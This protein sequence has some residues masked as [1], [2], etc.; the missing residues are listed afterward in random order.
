MERLAPIFKELSAA[1]PATDAATRADLETPA[2]LD[3][4]P[5]PL[6]VKRR[7]MGPAMHSAETL[8]AAARVKEAVA[9]LREAELELENDPWIGPAPPTVMAEVASTYEAE[10]F[11]E[12]NW[13][14]Y[15]NS[16]AQP[17]HRDGGVSPPSAPNNG[18]LG[19]LQ[20]GAERAKA[21]VESSLGTEPRIGRSV[22]ETVAQWR[23]PLVRPII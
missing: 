6:E 9:R 2:F 4:G 20:C 12:V 16:A 1:T 5:G 17:S 22:W 15:S 21:V 14:L 7:V 3:S 8:A 10:R 18:R 11:E 23:N 13:D 19:I